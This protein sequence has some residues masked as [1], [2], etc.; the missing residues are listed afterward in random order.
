M[1]RRR[2]PDPYAAGTTH[3]VPVALTTTDVRV[4][5]FTVEREH[6]DVS[7]VSGTVEL[8]DGTHAPCVVPITTLRSPHA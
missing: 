3:L 6:T 1:L 8:P 5:R 4:L 7:E 2:R